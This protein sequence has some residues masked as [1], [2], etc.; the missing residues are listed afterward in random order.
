MANDSKH[1]HEL[2]RRLLVALVTPKST[3][4][5]NIVNRVKIAIFLYIN[6]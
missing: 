4:A 2:P 1:R 6:T 3:H 5:G